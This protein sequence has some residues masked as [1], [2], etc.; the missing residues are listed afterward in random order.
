METE[1]RKRPHVDEDEG[2]QTKKRALVSPNG[3]PRVNGITEAD[4]PTDT[5]H[6]EVNGSFSSQLTGQTSFRGMLAVPKRG[7]LP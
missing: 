5:D 1:S 3:S 7:H 4:E 6:V 2:L